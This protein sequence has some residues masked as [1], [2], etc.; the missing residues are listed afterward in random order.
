MTLE[1]ALF[2]DKLPRRGMTL[3][4][5]IHR[6]YLDDRFSNELFP[7]MPLGQRGCFGSNWLEQA[8]TRT[9]T[10]PHVPAAAGGEGTPRALF[11]NTERD[12]FSKASN[13]VLCLQ[14]KAQAPSAPTS[15]GG[16]APP[17]RHPC[18]A[19]TATPC[20][21]ATPARGQA[22]GWEGRGSPGKASGPQDARQRG[23]RSG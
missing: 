9:V 16:P 19:P 8:R 22:P 18:P 14:S 1:G 11:P 4:H 6:P 10:H 12:A 13:A 15:L 2:W 17:L 23:Q 3:P 20:G 5:F 21:E 7:V